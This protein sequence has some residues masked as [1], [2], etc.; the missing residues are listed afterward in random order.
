MAVTIYIKVNDESNFVDYI[1]Y[2]VTFLNCKYGDDIIHVSDSTAIAHAIKVDN[3]YYAHAIDKPALT[4][5]SSFPNFHYFA[6]NGLCTRIENLPLPQEDILILKL[7]YG[8]THPDY[9][10]YQ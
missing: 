2:N 8:D 6:I 5:T 1:M 3:I 7:K 9:I 10:H 4:L